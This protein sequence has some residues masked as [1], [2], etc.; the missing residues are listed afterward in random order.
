[1]DSNL[2]LKESNY[3]TSV[4]GN[5]EAKAALENAIALNPLI[6]KAFAKFD[7][8]L[9]TGVLLYGPPGTGKTLLARAT[10][11]SLSNM[12]E[13]H[14]K[15]KLCVSGRLGGSFITLQASQVVRSEIGNSEKIIVSAFEMARANAPSVIFI[16]EFQ[17]L[18]TE[19]GK[20]SGRLATTLLQCMDDVATWKDAD[21]QVSKIQNG[22]ESTENL[23]SRVVVLGATNTPWMI[24]YA[25]LRPGRFDRVVHV[26]LPTFEERRTIL[27]IHLSRMRIF[28]S[29]VTAMDKI[30]M[31]MAAVCKGFSGADLEALCR[32][33]AV[34]CL[35]E[36]EVTSTCVEAKQLFVEDKHFQQARLHD[37][38]NTS[39]VLLVK[40]LIKWRQQKYPRY[41]QMKS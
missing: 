38:Q 4:G 12:H 9:P 15:N 20:G 6:R 33:A 14:L 13:S 35:R 40:K 37:V 28:P 26:G 1:M 31:A 34:R 25:F 24:D 19:R 3:A 21:A 23:T 36:S 7:L 39:D 10:A 32:A 29:S 17:A 41:N 22:F 2:S 5:T 27:K 16:D 8:S 11:E 18:F 30:I